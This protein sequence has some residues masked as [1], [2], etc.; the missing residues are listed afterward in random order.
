MTVGVSD[1]G[2]GGGFLG[3]SDGGSGYVD[4]GVSDTGS[5]GYDVGFIPS[6]YVSVD[7]MA[8]VNT[9]VAE[10]DYGMGSIDRCT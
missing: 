7:A 6:G 3:V 5:N 8:D 10:P 9:S 4:P 2:S 1:I